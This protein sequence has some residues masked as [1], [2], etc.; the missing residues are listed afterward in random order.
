MVQC[1]GQKYGTSCKKVVRMPQ[2]IKSWDKYQLCTKCSK[3][4]HTKSYRDLCDGV[5]I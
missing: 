3:D 1:L 2:H 5:V 4:E